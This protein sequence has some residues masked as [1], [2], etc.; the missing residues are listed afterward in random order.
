MSK[1]KNLWYWCFISKLGHWS[2]SHVYKN[3]VISLVNMFF[4]FKIAAIFYKDPVIYEAFGFYGANKPCF[5]GL[6]LV[7]ENIFL[8]YFEVPFH[9]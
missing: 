6:M 3:L 1:Y 8:I 5:I 9:W 2:Y 4:I 7:I